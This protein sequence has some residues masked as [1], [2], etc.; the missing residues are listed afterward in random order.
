MRRSL[1]KGPFWRGIV[2]FSRYL[3]QQTK[4]LTCR[5]SSILF[6]TKSFQGKGHVIESITLDSFTTSKLDL[7]H[8]HW[9]THTTINVRS[10]IWALKK[11][12]QIVKTSAASFSDGILVQLLRG[13]L[14]HAVMSRCTRTT[15]RVFRARY[16]IKKKKIVNLFP[17]TYIN[18]RTTE[19]QPTIEKISS[20]E[21]GQSLG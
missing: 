4:I 11:S 15:N 21:R 3:S 12:K 8:Y 10:L 9:L 1:I 14:T 5:E 13:S 18:A 20:T 7:V 19:W 17:T 16:E 6:V 2:F